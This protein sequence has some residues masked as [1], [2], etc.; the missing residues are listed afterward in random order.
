M[1]KSYV[2]KN[3]ISYLC[4]FTKISNLENI[5]V[6]G[7]YPRSDLIL[8][9]VEFEHN[10]GF[11]HDGHMNAT[12]LS[13]SF[14]AYKMFYKYQCDNPDIDY[15]VIKIKPSVLW[16][17]D[18]AFSVTNAAC[19]SITAIPLNQKK[20]PG[21][22]LKL[23]GEIEGKPTR[24]ELQIP[25]NYPTDPQAEVLVFGHIETNFIEDINIKS[26]NRVKDFDK[27]VKIAQKFN[28]YK[29]FFNEPLFKPR[30]DW[31]HWPKSGE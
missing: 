10:D 22:F 20:G 24:K 16:E 31:A 11:R 14:P 9:G 21:A 27:I 3:G 12:C 18:C 2:D 5:L 6:N 23:F 30:L 19:S 8:S 4:H 13:I 29:Y 17:K 7:L 15:A 25:A 1:I 26:Q 28:N